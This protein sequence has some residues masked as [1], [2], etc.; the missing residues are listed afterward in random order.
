M[1]VFVQLTSAGVDVGPFDIYQWLAPNW[2]LVESGVSR[3]TLILGANYTVDDNAT[4]IRVQSSGACD[5]YLDLVIGTTTTTTTTEALATTTTTTTVE[6]TTTTTTT[7]EEPGTTTTTTTTENPGTTTTTTTTEDLGTTTTTTTTEDLGT[8]TT[9]STSSTTTTTT[10]LVIH[11]ITIMAHPSQPTIDTAKVYYS[12]DAGPDVFLGNIGTN[13]C[14]L[15]GVI[16]VPDGSTLHLGV[17]DTAGT[18]CIEF[19]VALISNI[20]PA[21]Y[22]GYCGTVNVGS[23][24]GYTVPLPV[25]GSYDIAITANCQGPGET[26]V[27]C[28]SPATTTTTTTL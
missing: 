13:L 25:G 17:L 22:V 18:A 10:T 6:P 23:C 2:V 3:A 5:N 27:T 14:E 9:T 19:D 26:Y 28:T 12:I 8:T 1:I 11:D 7:T 20:C 16:P 21:G 24:G 4:I 15:I